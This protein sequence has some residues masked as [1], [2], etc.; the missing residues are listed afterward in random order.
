[1]PSLVVDP[2]WPHPERAVNAMNDVMREFFTA[3]HGVADRRRPRA[4]RQGGADVSAVRQAHAAG[5]R[6]AGSA[7]LKRDNVDLVT[8]PIAEITPRGRPLRGRRR[9]RRWTSSSSP[10]ASTPIAILWPMEI[11]GRDGVTLRRALGRGAARL[12][13]HHRAGL[14]EPVLSLRAGHQ[15]RARR[16]HHL[17]LRVPGPLRDGLPGG[18]APG[19]PLRPW[20]AARRSTTRTPSASTPA[21]ARWCGHIPA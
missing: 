3:V 2:E 16:Q 6:H 21:T 4:A 1:M 18:A 11:V 5:Q 14:S 20:S 10:P 7:T 13:R 9:V 8:E 19:R 17:P 15:P 12:P